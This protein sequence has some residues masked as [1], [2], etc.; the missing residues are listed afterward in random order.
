[1]FLRGFSVFNF[2]RKTTPIFLLKV[3]LVVVIMSVGVLRWLFPERPMDYVGP[4]ALLDTGFTLVLILFIAV[5]ASGIGVK[6]LNLLKLNFLMNLEYAVFGVAIG[7]GVIAYGVMALGLAGL[8]FPIYI[9]AWILLLTVL[10]FREIS[11]ILGRILSWI[12][13]FFIASQA[14]ELWKKALLVA[15]GVILFLTLIQALTP[16]WDYDGLMYHLEGPRRFLKYGSLL[17]MSEIW[18]ANG[19]FTIEMLFTIGIALGT[20]VFS[21]IVHLIFAILLI[22]STYAFGERYFGLS[23]GWISAAILLGIPVLSL[24]AGFAYVDMAWALYEFLSVY[25]LFIWI[26]KKKRS[27]LVLAGI[28]L[29][30]ALGSKY[31]ALGGALVLGFIVLWRSKGRSWKRALSDV[32]VFGLAALLVG[33]PWYLKNWVWFGN[34]VYP[35]YFGGVEWPAERV[36]YLMAY[37]RSFGTGREI[38]DYLLLPWNLYANYEQ[39]TTFLGSIEIPSILFL[40]AL[41]YPLAKK[42]LVMNILAIYLLPRF[43]LW[44][45][46]SQQIRFLMPLFPILSIVTAWVVVDFLSRLVAS[47][48]SGIMK[49]GILGGLITTTIIYAMILQNDIRP[50]SVIIGTESKNDFLTRTVFDYEAI[51]YIHDHLGEDDR[52]MMMWDGQGYYCGDM[53]IPDAEQSRWTQLSAS[54]N[55]VQSIQVT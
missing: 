26:D 13:N 25:A 17:L 34:P 54:V 9:M 38:W 23:V 51:K 22:L 40:L 31:L 42:S 53:C 28:M 15:A 1:M 32:T 27:W 52:V 19:P 16:P 30:F 48:V 33:S 43:I 36:E 4:R 18:Q 35:L 46:G 6:V 20:D 5:I 47:R 14:L 49:V 12:K 41:L 8:L 37:L 3:T 29:G 39:F 11:V 7:F 2:N 50:W 45:L 55:D 44:S 10:V 24:W 21:K